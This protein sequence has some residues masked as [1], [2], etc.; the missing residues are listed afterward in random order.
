MDI[1]SKFR[2]GL[3]KTSSFLASNIIHSL[4]SKQISSE[5][6]SDIETTLISADIGLEVTELLVNRIKSIKIV[7]QSDATFVLKLL[8]ESIHFPFPVS[9]S[10]VYSY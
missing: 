2:T 6:I 5:T 3:K 10:K 7:N 4:T 8:V 1:L 9:K